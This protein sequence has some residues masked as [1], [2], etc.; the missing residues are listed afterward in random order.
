MTSNAS[1]IRFRPTSASTWAVVMALS[2]WRMWLICRFRCTVGLYRRPQAQLKGQ[3]RRILIVYCI[4][5]VRRQSAV[6]L[7]SCAFRRF[8]F[9]ERPDFRQFFCEV[10]IACPFRYRHYQNACRAGVV[11]V[12]FENFAIGGSGELAFLSCSSCSSSSP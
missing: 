12:F 10:G 7:S 5:P 11:E 9:D 2:F 3:P 1:K 6:A 4:Y 8:N